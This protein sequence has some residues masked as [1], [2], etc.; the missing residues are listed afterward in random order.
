MLAGVIGLSLLGCSRTGEPWQGIKGRRIVAS[1]PPLACFAAKV[2]GEDGKVLPLLTSTG[3]HHYEATAHDLLK[4]RGA[5]LFLINGLDLDDGFA[6]RLKRNCGNPHLGLIEV[7]DFIPKDKL[8][9]L[10][11][12]AH[13][14]E[15]GHAGHK[16]DHHGHSHGEYDPHI[17]LGLEE[18]ILVVQGIAKE[19]AEDDRKNADSYR[20]RADAYCAELKDLHNFGQ[21]ELKD[22]TE[23]SLIT[24]HDSFYYFA[25]SFGLTVPGTIEIRPGEEP[26]SAT[27]KKLIALCK[28]QRVRLIAVEPQYPEKTAKTLLEELKKG[29]LEDADLVRLDPLETAPADFRPDYYVETMRANIKNLADKLR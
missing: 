4:L 12:G 16:H 9:K 20:K 26:D 5:D 23:R 13:G 7:G 21:R 24:F 22:K 17:W 28:E 15:P 18:A 11:A 14:H 3:P 1:F 6:T 2:V 27:L 8:R 25:R 10:T 29:G 19:L